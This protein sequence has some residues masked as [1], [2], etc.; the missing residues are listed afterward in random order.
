MP[1][2]VPPATPQRLWVSGRPLLRPD[3][4]NE[5]YSSRATAAG[6][7]HGTEDGAGCR[8]GVWPRAARYAKYDNFKFRNYALEW[9]GPTGK[10][11]PPVERPR[12]QTPHCG[13][14]DLPMNLADKTVLVTGSTDGVG[15]LVAQR[16]A[17]A[18]A[19][20]LLHGRNREKGQRTLA[21]IRA[22]TGSDKL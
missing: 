4:A 14:E 5:P 6:P 19:H 21:D 18:G 2:D 9:L 22:A 13:R 1:S 3:A 15:R 10:S 20:V 12:T 8:L 16:L 11:R 7:D 17:Q